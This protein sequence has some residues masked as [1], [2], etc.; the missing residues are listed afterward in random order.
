MANL[1]TS[2]LQYMKSL[3]QDAGIIDTF[4]LGRRFVETDIMEFEEWHAISLAERRQRFWTKITSLNPDAKTLESLEKADHK[5]TK[6]FGSDSSDEFG[7]LYDV[8]MNIYATCILVKGLTHEQTHEYYVVLL[9]C[10]DNWCQLQG[11]PAKFTTHITYILD[12]PNNPIDRDITANPSRYESY[13]VILDSKPVQ[14][15]KVPEKTYYDIMVFEH[16]NNALDMF[17]DVD[18]KAME[19]DVMFIFILGVMFCDPEFQLY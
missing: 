10:Y 3:R 19:F 6:E 14:I 2:V 15:F 13:F 11:H 17:L 18:V 1:R 9:R 4:E 12:N 16:F 5:F 7:K 8:W